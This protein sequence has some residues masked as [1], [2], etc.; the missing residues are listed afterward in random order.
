MKNKQK[1]SCSCSK[2]KKLLIWL[3][4]YFINLDRLQDF[5]ENKIQNNSPLF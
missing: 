2:I 5:S 3:E 1:R 4:D